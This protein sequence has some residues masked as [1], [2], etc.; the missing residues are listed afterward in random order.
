MGAVV[1]LAGG[2]IA[3]LPEPPFPL[4]LYLFGESA[5]RLS[6]VATQ[7]RPAGSLPGTLAYEVGTAVARTIRRVSVPG[8]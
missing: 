4:A 7:S 5:V 1:G 3:P 2:S 8:S 6:I